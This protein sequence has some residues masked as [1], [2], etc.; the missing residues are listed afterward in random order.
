MNRF[1]YLIALAAAALAG[2]AFAGPAAAANPVAT[3]FELDTS[4][5][6]LL[7]AKSGGDFWSV[8]D[9]VVSSFST[10]GVLTPIGDFDEPRKLVADA[11]EG[12]D[13]NLWA[14]A[15]N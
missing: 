11:V 6:S 5:P 1:K 8:N 13:G 15:A 14:T 7:V 12:P 10:G 4:T 9:D 3:Q 2:L